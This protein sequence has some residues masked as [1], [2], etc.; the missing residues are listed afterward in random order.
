MDLYGLGWI[1]V[2]DRR[3][4]FSCPVGVLEGVV[5]ILWAWPVGD[6]L[7]YALDGHF[8]PNIVYFLKRS[9]SLSKISR[10]WG[11]YTIE[12]ANSGSTANFPF[13]YALFQD[14][15]YWGGSSDAVLVRLCWQ[16]FRAPFYEC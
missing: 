6:I 4:G 1:L 5:E 11:G 2:L 9:F 16:R 3:G 10:L 13:P 12:S 7:R 8:S 15:L 14:T